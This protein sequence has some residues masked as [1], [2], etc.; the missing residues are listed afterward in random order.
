MTERMQKE[1]DPTWVEPQDLPSE[2]TLRP[3]SLKD[4]IGQSK[5]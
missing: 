3:Q 4:Y 5:V 2:N 1:V